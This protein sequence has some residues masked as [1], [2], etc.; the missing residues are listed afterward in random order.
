MKVEMEFSD[1]TVR[2]FD[3]AAHIFDVCTPDLHTRLIQL[4]CPSHG[5]GLT[6]FRKQLLGAK[7]IIFHWF[8]DCLSPG[9]EACDELT[10]IAEDVF[11]QDQ[12]RGEE[13]TGAYLI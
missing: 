9:G 2:E 4:R 1:G 13:F 8:S 7:I 5:N 11:D 6:R 10:Q 3:D 12:N